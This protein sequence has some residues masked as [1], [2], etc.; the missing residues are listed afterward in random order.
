MHA[1]RMFTCS[2][3]A[4]MRSRWLRR[5]ASLLLLPAALAGSSCATTAPALEQRADAAVLP[6]SGAAQ[7]VVYP[8]A[9]WERHARPEDAGW[10]EDG[11]A[12]VRHEL[13]Q[14][15]STGFMAV[16]GGR[17]FFEY[18][19]VEAVSYLASVR[20]SVLSMLFGNY[21]ASG[22][23]RLDR[24]LAEL[25]IDDHQGL[26]D[27]ERRA[28]VRDLL[29]A[30][31]GVYHPASNSGDDLA[32][33]PARGSQPAGTYYLYNNWDFNA[34]GTIFEQE[35]GRNIYDALE[36]D[37][38]RPLGMEDFVRARQVKT[39]DL[40][41]S[42]HPAYHMHLSTRD[43]ARIGYLMLRE[44]RWQDRQLVP[45]EWVH[46]STRLWTPRSA[47][48]PER[49]RQS[50][51]GYG[52]LW[53]IF[54]DPALGPEYAGA[55]VAHG[56]VGQHILVM[57]ALDLVVAH[58]TRQGQAGRV[59]HEEFHAVVRTLVAAHCGSR[60]GT[61]QEPYDLVLRNGRI[62]DG[63]GSP[64]YR[65]DVAIRDGTI[66]RIAHAI[67][68]PA[69]RVIDVDGQVVAPGFI[70]IH[71]HARRGIFERPTA[72][73][74]VR[75]GVTTLVEGPDGSSP[76]PLAPFL[77]SLDSL[78]KSVNIA[79][80]IGQGSVRS[81]VIGS[82]DRAATPAEL[83]R[84]R[85]LVA[86]GM[87]DGAF[88]LSTGLFYVP[89]TFTPTEEVVELARVAGRL[90]GIHIS[91]MRD[92][93]AGVV[94]SVAETIRIGEEGGLPTQVT[95]HKVV[96][97]GYWGASTE[98]LRLIEEARA[99]GVD[100]TV[101]QYPYSASATSV[102]SALM[103]AWSLEGGSARI[104]SRLLDP[105]QRARIRSETAEIIR[106]ERGGG[107]PENVVM[108]R[109]G[110]DPSLA[111]QSLARI[112]R[113]RG[114]E[115]TLTNAAETV[116]WIVEQGGCS[117]VFHAI[118]E[119]DIERILRH[120][121]TMIASDGEIPEVGVGHPHPRSYGTFARVLGR[122]VRE[123]GTLS[124]EEAVRK[125]SA[126][127]AQRLGLA[128]RGL[129]RPG[130]KADIVVFDPAEVRDMAT[131]EEPHQFSQG[132]S[133]VVVNGMPVLEAGA[134]TAAR[135]GRVLYGPARP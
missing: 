106:L 128:D 96:G 85:E 19:D 2:H 46:E 31:S 78:P 14:L 8:G 66:V 83:Q 24:T 77:A 33:A 54:D 10:S 1:L 49:R 35:T 125:M 91:H 22:V 109:C 11:L 104:R 39:G 110:F 56:A 119:D 30:R 84:M 94:A 88:G 61:A 98:T 76:L 5:K 115:P 89:G 57:P 123:R 127:P 59:S 112:T 29:T 28:T 37:L 6:G 131:F 51:F 13:G 36:T 80:F 4:T 23:I 53:W 101:D 73:N 58:K 18:G 107:D 12:K 74:Y 3:G 68:G 130:M 121:A 100:A 63:T 60:C 82:T 114:M 9:S 47:M 16:A 48:N 72:E 87:R 129:L 71:T 124:L 21:V 64:W 117:G 97:P 132:V 27:A 103:P 113:A 133:L 7:T 116:L 32:S 79:M 67:E 102:Q 17:V 20:K 111:G 43:M 75:Q 34:L 62:V 69:R 81:E 55:Y 25:G 40:S 44:G 126:F 86:E 65:G 134:M 42:L 50:S 122:Y 120:P 95:H 38:A 45:R 41:A 52:Y 105:A 92:E 118:N 108:S 99:R 93:A 26:T 15:Y 135:P 70:D 90:G